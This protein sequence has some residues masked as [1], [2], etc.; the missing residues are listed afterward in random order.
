MHLA[1]VKRNLIFRNQF[2]TEISIIFS[3]IGS[4]TSIQGA[5]YVNRHRVKSIKRYIAKILYLFGIS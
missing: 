4:K 1:L 3:N 5:I 2:F